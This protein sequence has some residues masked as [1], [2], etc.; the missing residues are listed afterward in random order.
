MEVSSDALA[1]ARA[2]IARHQLADRVACLSSN[3]LSTVPEA[4]RFDL[5]ISNPP[6]I[7]TAEI[8]TL[9]PEVRD[10]DPRLA[11]DGGP[12]GLNCFR[13]L[14]AEAG[15]RLKPDG[16]VMLEF[17]GGQ[18]AEV[19]QIFARQNWVVEAVIEDYSRRA[20]F[21]VARTA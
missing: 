7:P 20:R 9:Q 21:L 6:Y 15:A 2:N 17:G 5:I 13:Q 11:L 3:G 14:A 10:H 4:S 12:D 8:A 19:S 1:L 18:A 16:R